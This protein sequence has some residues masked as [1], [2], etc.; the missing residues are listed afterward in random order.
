MYIIIIILY[1]LISIRDGLVQASK[2]Y[3]KANNVKTPDYD[4]TKEKPW[5]I[6][7]DCEYILYLLLFFKT[8]LFFHS[9][10]FFNFYR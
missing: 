3:G 5:I 4:E 9:Y 6:Y 10:Y 7:Q 1:F 8:Y 2:R